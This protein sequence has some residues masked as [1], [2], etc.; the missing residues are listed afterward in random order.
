MICIY[1]FICNNLNSIYFTPISIIFSIWN[2]FFKVS[3]RINSINDFYL[4]NIFTSRNYY[5][6]TPSIKINANTDAGPTPMALR[7]PNSLTRSNTA[8]S[9][10]FSSRITT[11]T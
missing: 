3:Y 5:I 6:V 8:I 10:A 9:M 11:A 1:F 7:I 4:I 2:Y